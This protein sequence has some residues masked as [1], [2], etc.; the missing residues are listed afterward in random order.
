[1][2]VYYSQ[3]PYDTPKLKRLLDTYVDDAATR[4]R[5]LDQVAKNITLASHK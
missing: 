3:A 5:I 1:M 4:Q 2:V